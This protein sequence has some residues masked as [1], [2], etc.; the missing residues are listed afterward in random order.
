[1]LK[2]IIIVALILLCI[3]LFIEIVDTQNKNENGRYQVYISQGFLTGNVVQPTVYLKMDTRTGE[4]W[5]AAIPLA[6]G[7]TRIENK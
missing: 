6:D 5:S 4:V 1:M 7:W 3:V 2:N